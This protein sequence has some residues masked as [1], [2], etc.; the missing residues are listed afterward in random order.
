M[1]NIT[2]GTRNPSF[3]SPAMY[4]KIKPGTGERMKTGQRYSIHAQVVN[5]QNR[6]SNPII[7]IMLPGIKKPYDLLSARYP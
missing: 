2:A 5:E 7:V 1:D 6:N 4:I 3:L